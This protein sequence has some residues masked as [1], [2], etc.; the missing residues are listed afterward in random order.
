MLGITGTGGSGKS[1]LTDELVRRFR[2]DQEDKL[3][4]AVLAVDPT[5]RKGGGA[6]LGDRIRMNAIDTLGRRSA[7]ARRVF[8]RIPSFAT[9]GSGT[10]AARLP[11]RRH[12]RLPGRRL[13]PGDRGDAGHRPGR[14]RRR[15]A[16]RLR[17]CT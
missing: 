10:R 1:S 5:R 12:R 16:R 6:L 9:R 7:P 15:P 4:V 2:L 8:F 13:R 3:R 14:R 17:R 11:R